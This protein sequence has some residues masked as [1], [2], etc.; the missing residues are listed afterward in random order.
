[1]QLYGAFRGSLG[2]GL[3]VMIRYCG[4]ATDRMAGRCTRFQV[5][6]EKVAKV[7]ISDFDTTE[8]QV[9][10]E[11][12]NRKWMYSLEYRPCQQKKHH[13]NV[14][15]FCRYGGAHDASYTLTT[16]GRWEK[17]FGPPQCG[18]RCQELR[19]VP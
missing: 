1:M 12:Q 4:P 19:R 11:T 13:I 5:V 14:T 10:L 9:N 3:S 8:F 7:E 6:F 16:G 17:D 18:R 15:R 2:A